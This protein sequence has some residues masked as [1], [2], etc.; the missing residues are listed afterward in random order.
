MAQGSSRLHTLWLK[1]LQGALPCGSG[2]FQASYAVAQGSSRLHTLWLRGLPGTY[3][4][5]W[6]SSRLYTL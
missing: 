6:G 1:G 3:A 4:V 5:A 2:V